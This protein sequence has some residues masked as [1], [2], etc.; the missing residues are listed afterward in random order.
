METNRLSLLYNIEKIYNENNIGSTDYQLARYLLDNYTNI[1][2]LNIYDVAEVNHVSRAT[3]RRF[4]SHLG[5]RNFKELKAHF[6]DFRDGIDKYTTFYSGADFR[7]ELQR[8]INEMIDELAERMNTSEKKNIVNKIIQA[9]EVVLIAS[10]TLASGIRVFQQNLAIFGK[11]VSLIVSKE[12][13]RQLKECLTQNSLL[14]V[15]SIS[16]LLA[17]T[18]ADEIENLN[19]YK[20]IFTIKRDPKFNREYNKIYHLCAQESEKVNEILLY[21]YGITFVLDLLFKEYLDSYQKRGD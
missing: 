6:K 1:P 10:S 15:F 21:T 11:R 14:I 13:I 2:L 5:Y 12:E 16:G 8:Q 9:D 7:K 17:E 18:L 4:C 20:V 19:L 3:V